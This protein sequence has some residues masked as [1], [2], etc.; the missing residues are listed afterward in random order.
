[1]ISY[2]FMHYHISSE[3]DFEPRRSHFSKVSDRNLFFEKSVSVP[4]YSISIIALAGF[5]GA[6]FEICPQKTTTRIQNAKYQDLTPIKRIVT[7][8]P[9]PGVLAIWIS[10]LWA[11]MIFCTIASPRPVPDGLVV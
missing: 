8:V 5:F 4:I 3:K 11:S 9:W 10:A 7:V 1:M 2:M 6:R